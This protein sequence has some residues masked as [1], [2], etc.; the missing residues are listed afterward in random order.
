MQPFVLS[1]RAASKSGAQAGHLEPEAHCLPGA[2]VDRG[3]FEPV[4]DPGRQHGCGGWLAGA[5]RGVEGRTRGLT[6]HV[7]RSR[8]HGVVNVVLGGAAVATDK[9][10]TRSCRQWLTAAAHV[11]LGGRTKLGMGA[12]GSWCAARWTPRPRAR[13]PRTGRRRAAASPDTA[14][15]EPD[16]P[17][18]AASCRA[19]RAEA[20]HRGRRA[21]SSGRFPAGPSRPSLCGDARRGRSSCLRW[22]NC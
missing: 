7:D 20:R 16:P 15:A 17:P 21:P 2:F 18:P 5:D 19:Y 6:G 22:G 9:C 1:Q 14:A 3:H 10:R 11:A 4:E 13:G 8:Q 12:P